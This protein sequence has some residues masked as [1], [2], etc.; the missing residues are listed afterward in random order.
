MPVADAKLNDDE[1]VAV[2]TSYPAMN[3]QFETATL[4]ED[5]DGVYFVYVKLATVPAAGA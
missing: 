5:A 1:M 2:M 3:A 4:D